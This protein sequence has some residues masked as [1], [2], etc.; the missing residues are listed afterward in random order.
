MLA[1]IALVGILIVFACTYGMANPAGLL[2]GVRRFANPAGYRFAIA[3]R[4]VLGIAALVAAP[5]SRAPLFLY[6]VGGIALV[7]AAVLLVIGLPGYHRIMDRVD[8][9]PP[10]FL[11]T[12]LVLGMA[13]G[14]SLIWVTGIA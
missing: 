14:V 6:L 12:G 9:F 7:A 4:V 10:A 1:L 13:F 3:V 2:A 8:G 5:A 11:R